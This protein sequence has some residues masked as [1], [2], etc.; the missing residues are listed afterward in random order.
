MDHT[1][2]VAALAKTA[3]ESGRPLTRRRGRLR[4]GSL[5]K[6]ERKE[7]GLEAVNPKHAGPAINERQQAGMQTLQSAIQQQSRTTNSPQTRHRLKQTEKDNGGF[8]RVTEGLYFV[9]KKAPKGLI[10]P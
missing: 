6:Q 5:R 9:A 2:D 3:N 4:R 7:E 10:L 1:G 8:L